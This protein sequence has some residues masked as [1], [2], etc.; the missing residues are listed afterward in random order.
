MHYQTQ[1]SYVVSQI[2]KKIL[3]NLTMVRLIEFNTQLT[4]QDLAF[5]KFITSGQLQ[6]IA[7]SEL[8]NII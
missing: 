8:N 1:V 3:I 4:E 6:F 5:N 2:E 7:C